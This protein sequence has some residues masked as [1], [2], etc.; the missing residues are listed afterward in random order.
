[1]KPGR[2]RKKDEK[3]TQTKEK[4]MI[5]Y[6]LE[7]GYQEHARPASIVAT[8]TKAAGLNGKH[9]GHIEIFPSFSTVDLPEGMPREVFDDLKQAKVGQ[10]PLKISEV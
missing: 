4:G 1:M 3:V 6:R 5:R 9:I 8:I 7:V 10:Y 2:E